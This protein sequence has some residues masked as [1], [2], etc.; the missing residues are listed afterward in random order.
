MNNYPKLAQKE[1]KE[2]LTNWGYEAIREGFMLHD[3]RINR[4]L[5]HIGECI[6]YNRDTKKM[7]RHILIFDAWELIQVMR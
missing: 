6:N 4:A 2:L 5:E 1:A 7:R 3:E